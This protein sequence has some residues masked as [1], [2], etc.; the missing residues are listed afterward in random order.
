MKTPDAVA[1]YTIISNFEIRSVWWIAGTNEEEQDELWVGIVW[2]SLGPDELRMVF[3]D[4]GD[5]KGNTQ[6]YTMKYYKGYDVTAGAFL[7][8]V[9]YEYVE[10]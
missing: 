1:A 2:D 9:M 7:G 4:A 3:F 10:V 6:F 5:K 8:P